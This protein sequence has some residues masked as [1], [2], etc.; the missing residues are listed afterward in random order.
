LRDELKNQV[1]QRRAYE[2][3]S[4]GGVIDPRIIDI[5]KHIDSKPEMVAKLNAVA[6]Y[7]LLIEKT[8]PLATG[9]KNSD[10]VKRYIRERDRIKEEI[11]NLRKQ[12]RPGNGRG[13]LDLRAGLAAAPP[14]ACGARKAT[15]VK[16]FSLGLT[17]QPV[18]A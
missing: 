10:L 11:A 7:D 5:D 6:E 12:L 17:F 1:R 13:G 14:G 4:N 16:E 18:N 2:Q 15:V 3:I 8:T 9:G